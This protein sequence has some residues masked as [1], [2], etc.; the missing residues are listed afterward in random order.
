MAVVDEALGTVAG[1]QGVTVEQLADSTLATLCG[2][3]RVPELKMPCR[4]DA[5]RPSG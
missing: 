3:E 5:S 4:A 2:A 1:Q